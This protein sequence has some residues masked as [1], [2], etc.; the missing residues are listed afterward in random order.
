MHEESFGSKSLLL[1]LY[2][3]KLLFLG[4]E[5]TME[6]DGICIPREGGGVP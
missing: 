1:H 5:G 3:P 6:I 4:D 2:N